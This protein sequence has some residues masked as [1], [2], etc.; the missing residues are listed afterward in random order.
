[1]GG[2]SFKCPKCSKWFI[3]MG[4]LKDHIKD[5]HGLV[6]VVLQG[7]AESTRISHRQKG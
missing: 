2:Q 4:A 1:M 3:Y 7:V 5:K 6:R